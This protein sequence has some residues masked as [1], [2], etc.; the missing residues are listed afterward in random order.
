M[1]YPAIQLEA[2]CAIGNERQVLGMAR[3]TW[4]FLY[5]CAQDGEQA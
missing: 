5:A 3:F 4:G 2:G 1:D